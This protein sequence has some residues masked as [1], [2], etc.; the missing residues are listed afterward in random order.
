MFIGSTVL[1][2]RP[3]VKLFVRLCYL[4]IILYIKGLEVLGILYCLSENW[5]AKFRS[6]NSQKFCFVDI[7][8]E[9]KNE[10]IRS[11]GYNVILWSNIS[12]SSNST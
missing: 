1:E 8:F 7:E 3:L 2:L 10:N 5:Q 4:N 9:C 12:D 11:Q 6:S